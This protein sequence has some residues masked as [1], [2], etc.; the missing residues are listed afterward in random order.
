M[1]DQLVAACGLYCGACRAYLKGKCKGC[2]E[3]K[4]AEK[5]CKVKNCCRESGIRSC[6][7]CESHEKVNECKKFN[8]IFSKAFK[9]IFGSNRRWCIERIRQVGYEEYAKEADLSKNYNGKNTK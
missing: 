9:L 2:R 3:N 6:A 4:A 8:N 5:W 7:D 1:S